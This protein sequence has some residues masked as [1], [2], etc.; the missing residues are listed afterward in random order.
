MMQFTEFHAKYYANALF[1]SVSGSHLENLIGTLSDANVDLNPHQVEAALFALKSPFCRGVILGDEVGLGKTIEAGIVFAQ[2]IAEGKKKVLL[3]IPANSRTQWK[4]EMLEKF[5]ISCEILDS[6]SYKKCIEA[7]HENP[8]D[9]EI[10]LIVSYN[11]AYEKA[12][13]IRKI[14]WDLVI[15]DEAHRL[16]NA[17]KPTSIMAKTLLDALDQSFKLLLTATPLNNTLMELYG[18]SRFIDS[19]IFGDM[20]SFKAQFSFLR[21]AEDPSLDDLIARVRQFCIRTLRRQVTEYIKYTERKLITQTFEPTKKEQ[22]FYNKFSAYLQRDRLWAIPNSGRPLVSMVLWKLLASSTFAIAGTLDKLILRLEFMYERGEMVRNIKIKQVDEGIGFDSEIPDM[23]PAVKRRKLNEGEMRSLKREIDELKEYAALAH[24]IKKN[25]KGEKLLVA[26][27]KGFEQ[28]KLLKAPQ[29]VVIF[30]ESRRTQEYIYEILQNSKYRNQ[31]ILYHGGLSSKKKDEAQ[32]LLRDKLKIMVA[33]EAAAESLNL[34]FSPMLINYDLPFNPQRIEQRIG[35]LHRYGQKFDVVVINF[36]NSHNLAD[37]RTYEILCD[38]FQLFEGVFGASDGILG[39]IDSLDFERRIVE[40]YQT[41]RTAQEIERSFKELRDSLSPQIDERMSD[42]KKK[43]LE[44][45]DD[46]VAERLKISEKNSHECLTRFD[47]ML[48]SLTRYV[49]RNNAEFDDENKSFVITKNPYYNSH[50]GYKRFGG[51]YIFKKD[52]PLSIRYRPKCS[53]AQTVI[54]DVLDDYRGHY[55]EVVFNLSDYAGKVSSLTPF[56]GKSGYLSLGLTEI[57]YP[58]R[59]EKRLLFA[60]FCENGTV[61]SQDQMRRMFDLSGESASTV[62][63]KLPKEALDQLYTLMQTEQNTIIDTVTTQDTDW[64]NEELTKLDK[65]A[66][67]VKQS[68]E[69]NIKNMDG[70]IAELRKQARKSVVL[71]DRLAIEKK[72]KELESKR[73]KQ[74]F[75]LY[76]EQDKIDQQKENLIKET[77]EKLRQQVNSNTIFDIRWRVI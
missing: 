43:I 17:Y 28:L 10:P 27:E 67:D 16:R 72:I 1:Y 29:K 2:K 13:L 33:T 38:K 65:W 53:L 47:T 44:N 58:K 57:C 66:Q 7:G 39:S 8:F 20:D 18:L 24:S 48:W 32:A 62:N 54:F 76:T 26:I 68:M 30:T 37:Q 21:S 74:R 64:F 12:D 22:E 60:G 35:R 19:Y 61:L 36:L 5:Y 15:I 31:V 41:C 69:K 50:Y 52:A 56:I 75:E 45:F 73:N 34:Q 40:I 63:N 70:E 9:S 23:L 46:V 14:K 4:N 25:A 51:E 55:G 6:E 49:L 42:I 77:Q 71:K 59:R 3:I 11:F